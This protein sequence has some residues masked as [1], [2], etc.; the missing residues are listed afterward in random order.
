MNKFTLIPSTLKYASAPDSDQE[1]SISFDNQ[2]REI[3]E[4]DRSQTINLAEV[5]Y[6]ER[7]ASTTFRPTFKINYLYN[8]TYTGTTQYLPFQ[9]NLY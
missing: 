2:V 5:F 1:V 9:Y 6:D 8:N 7:Q 4:F 3:T